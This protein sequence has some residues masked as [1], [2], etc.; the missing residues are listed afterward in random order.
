M[1]AA[2]CHEARRNDQAVAEVVPSGFLGRQDNERY[3]EKDQTYQA[4]YVECLG[5]AVPR[6]EFYKAISK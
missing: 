5:Y 3:Q 2:Y 4:G 6:I 1:K